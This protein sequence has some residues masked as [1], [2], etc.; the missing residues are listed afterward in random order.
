MVNILQSMHS[1]PINAMIRVE[2]EVWV[3]GDD[4]LSIWDAKTAKFACFASKRPKFSW[5]ALAETSSAI[6]AGTESGAI[7]LFDRKTKQERGQ[8]KQHKAPVTCMALVIGGLVWS[9]S[10]DN[11]ICIWK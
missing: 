6:W 10:A 4:G 11:E 8:V 1:K 9:C 5:K 2:D 7:V 3:A